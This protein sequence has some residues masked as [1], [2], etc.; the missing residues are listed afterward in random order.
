MLV[1]V[2]VSVLIAGSSTVTVQPGP[3]GNIL[4]FESEVSKR[5]P[6]NELNIV[7][8]I[9][10]IGNHVLHYWALEV[11]PHSYG[12]YLFCRNQG[13]NHVQSI[14]IYTRNPTSSVDIIGRARQLALK[15]GLS[16]PDSFVKFDN[17]C[18]L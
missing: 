7:T 13:S 3:T 5:L 8:H 18:Y 4:A 17:N 10:L 6:G 11:I 14:D 2:I 16:V 1:I 9:P 15:R 12:I